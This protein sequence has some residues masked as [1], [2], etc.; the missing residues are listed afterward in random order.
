M[1]ERLE[2]V[3]QALGSRVVSTSR[4]AGG[5]S[6]ET[7]LVTL[8]DRRVV[9]RFGG[10]DPAI[11]AGVMAA[12]RRHVPVPEVLL[13]TPSATVIEYVEGV[14][15]SDV[16]AGD[17]GRREAAELGAEV[18]RTV[19]GVA[20]VEFG[21]RGF[22]T[23]AS[24]DVAEERPWSEQL[25]EVAEHCMSA[26]PA[27]RLDAETR[28]GWVKLCA[29][30]ARALREID[31]HT[32]LVHSDI[33]PKNILVARLDSGW[34]VRSLLDWEFSYSGSPYADAANMA[35]FSDDYPAGFRDGFRDGFAGNQS[36]PVAADWAYLGDVLDMFALSDLTTRPVGHIVADR[37]A[38]HIRRLVRS[39]FGRTVKN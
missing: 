26:A 30:H 35:R 38:E 34:E 21:R 19:A 22:F 32:R 17:L 23:G 36:L 1:I 11:E 18:G 27:G 12:A 7:L 39:Q 5:F 3:A 10:S 8:A 25:A 24:L 16:L 37:A 13:V 4:L 28:R 2:S 20:R 29:V 31:W 33:N 14:V 15:L 9:V 6:H